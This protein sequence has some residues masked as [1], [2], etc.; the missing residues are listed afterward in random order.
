MHWGATMAVDEEL[1]TVDSET[2][3]VIALVCH[4]RASFAA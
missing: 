1:M 2:A 3:R 4:H